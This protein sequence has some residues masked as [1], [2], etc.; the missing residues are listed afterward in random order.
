MQTNHKPESGQGTSLS[1]RTFLQ[2]AAAGSAATLPAVAL[3]GMGGEVPDPSQL[4]D[5]QQLDACVAQ[6]KAIL[7]R[8]H[9]GAEC[10]PHYLSHRED[11]SWKFAVQGDVRYAAFEGD[12]FYEVSIEGYLTV[13]YLERDF[14]RCARSGAPIASSEFYW[15]TQYENGEVVGE[16][17]AGRPKIVR[18]VA[19]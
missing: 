11:G 3:G 1:R 9:P 6:L 5:E 7:A 13:V 10:S 19:P 4:T 15:V 8:M 16:R 18:K 14:R 17:A 12:G 2:F